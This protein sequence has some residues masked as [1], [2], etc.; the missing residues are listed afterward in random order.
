MGGELVGVG[1]SFRSLGLGIELG[2]SDLAS[3]DTLSY[4]AKRSKEFRRII[5]LSV[6]NLSYNNDL[7]K[8]TA[9]DAEFRLLK[10]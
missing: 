4:E 9:D 2:S 7:Y 8:D 5:S 10:S 3:Q 1:S 6:T